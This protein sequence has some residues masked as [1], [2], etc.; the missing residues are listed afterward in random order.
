ME[1]TIDPFHNQNNNN[2][3]TKYQ[4]REVGRTHNG[5][6]MDLQVRTSIGFLAMRSQLIFARINNREPQKVNYR[7]LPGGD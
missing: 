7:P 4:F 3:N 6:K 1:C 5:P 2:I